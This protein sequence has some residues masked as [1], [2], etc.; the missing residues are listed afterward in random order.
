MEST[1]SIKDYKID[2]KYRHYRIRANIMGGKLIHTSGFHSDYVEYYIRIETDYAKWTLKK[3]YDEVS[4][5]NTNLVSII[6]EIKK[7]FPHRR[8][9]KSTDD[10][11]GERIKL[12]KKYFNY[13]FS[14]INI[15]LIDELINFISIKSEIILLFIK[16][17]LMLNIQENNNV[18]IS[19]KNA[20][21]KIISNEESQIKNEREK[22][23]KE[24]IIYILE[25][26]NNYYDSILKYEMKR[27]ISFSWDEP[28]SQTPNIFVIKE[29]LNNL[30]E[31]SENK[32][33]ILQS[34]EN[35]FKTEA[36]S[37]RF[38]TKEIMLLYKGEENENDEITE[39]LSK[40][41]YN[42]KKRKKISSDFKFH[43][44]F[45]FV[46]PD[47]DDIYN[48]EGEEDYYLNNDTKI[49]GLFFI[50]GNY[51]KNML[52]SIG[53]IDLLN[54]LIDTEY[55]P[56][57]EI[58]INVFKSC[59][60][61]DYKM[62]NLSKIIKSNIGGDKTNLKA[63]KLLKLIFYDKSRNDYKRTIIEDNEVY[64]QYHNY[65]NKFIE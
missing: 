35:F 54:K 53:A 19:L 1:S 52:L 29:F 30:S 21:N 47:E 33:E 39:F 38:S 3:K 61:K 62:L 40:S 6:P 10:I 26:E 18:L 44:S 58:Y 59:E 51:N 22:K 48:S 64:K 49:N 16:K 14:N 27:Q 12:F 55:N 9:L 46:D 7:L 28:P 8:I 2:K 34:F 15:F 56:D 42:S 45:E 4:K 37:I 63:M 11:I 50:I 43:S 36:K 32:T 5:L 41:N 17:Y 25:N 31:K 60:M 23:S 13:L 57:A 24:D 20:Y 65:L